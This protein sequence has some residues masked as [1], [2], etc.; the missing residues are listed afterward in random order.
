MKIN[1]M[2]SGPTV[3]GIVAVTYP[4]LT[5]QRW[6]WF[7]LC[8]VKLEK[9]IRTVCYLRQRAPSHWVNFLACYWICSLWCTLVTNTKT[10]FSARN[11]CSVNF[12]VGTLHACRVFSSEWI[13]TL[14][15]EFAVSTAH[16]WHSLGHSLQFHK[17]TNWCQFFGVKIW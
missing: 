3:N 5:I 8:C 11:P 12:C 1:P 14:V 13:F 4:R 9:A 2:H 17:C 7:P 15:T 10:K 6:Q 16:L